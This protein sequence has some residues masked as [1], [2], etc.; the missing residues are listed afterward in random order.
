MGMEATLSH[1][2][3]D[4]ILVES[5]FG[6]RFIKIISKGTIN[7]KEQVREQ[8]LE[9]VLCVDED[10]SVVSIQEMHLSIA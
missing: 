5:T 7:I 1:Q 8:T 9:A 6:A 3:I 4:N 2:Q 10:N